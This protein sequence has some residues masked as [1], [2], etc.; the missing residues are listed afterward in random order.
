VRNTFKIAAIRAQIA[1][2]E[3]ER[4]QLLKMLTSSQVNIAWISERMDSIERELRFL[5]RDLELQE[6]E[7]RS[8][9]WN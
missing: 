5:Y 9:Q 1:F 4:R 8:E 7:M 3:A 6:Q 2:C